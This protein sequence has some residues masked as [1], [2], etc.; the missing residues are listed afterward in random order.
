MAEQTIK[1]DPLFPAWQIIL[2]CTLIEWSNR[3]AM[4]MAK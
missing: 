1:P 3:L 4:G 2:A